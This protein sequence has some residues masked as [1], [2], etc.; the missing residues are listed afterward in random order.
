MQT[1]EHIWVVI[2]D[3]QC[4]LCK[5]V[6]LDKYGRVPVPIELIGYREKWMITIQHGKCNDE[7]MYECYMTTGEFSFCPHCGKHVR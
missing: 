2:R 1:I 7:G 6:G 5:A 4:N 3:L